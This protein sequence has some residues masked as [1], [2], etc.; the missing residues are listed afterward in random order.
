MRDDVNGRTSMEKAQIYQRLSNINTAAVLWMLA[1]WPVCGWYIQRTF[2]QSDEPWGIV[3]LLSAIYFARQAGGFK[4]VQGKQLWFVCILLVFYMLS[5]NFAPHL[6]QGVVM[7]V[8]LWCWLLAGITVRWR[9]GIFGL[10]LLSLPIV[11]SVNFFAGYPLRF[12]VSK[13]AQ[14]MLSCFGIKSVQEGTVLVVGHNPISIDAPCSGISM[15]W[16]QLF[17]TML[18]A[19]YFKVSGA[20][21]LA[22]LGAASIGL[23]LLANSVRAV[24]LI[25]F[26][27]FCRIPDFSLQLSAFESNVHVGAGL[28][29]LM[30]TVAATAALASRLSQGTADLPKESSD[31]LGDMTIEHLQAADSK[32][33]AGIIEGLESKKWKLSN[34]LGLRLRSNALLYALCVC[35]SLVPFFASTTASAPLMPEPEWPKEILGHSIV[36]VPAMDEEKAFA[37]DFPGRMRRF[38]DGSNNFFVRTVNKE[39]RQL[40]PSSDCF[41]GMGY[42]IE[43][44]PLFES[45]DGTRW[46][47]FHAIKGNARYLVLEQLHDTQGNT[48]TDV[49]SWYWHA[50]THKS[51]GPWWAVTIA[52]AIN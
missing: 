3:A 8:A 13:I 11:P 23:V 6:V 33:N 2:D 45:T 32:L 15:L 19:C 5:Y 40:H 39:T 34:A 17:S 28:L 50:L 12:L 42:R 4:R 10:L 31:S 43:P 51:A 41:K 30:L 52:T 48:W 22:V 20:K 47:S 16:V 7:V 24:A 46:S 9:W 44:Q 49:S 14:L 21:R 26:D 37:A 35:A 29:T 27:C 25:L 18:L 1:F 38:T 36:A